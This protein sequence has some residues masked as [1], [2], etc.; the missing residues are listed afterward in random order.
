[1]PDISLCVN[2]DCPLKD[3]CYRR[4]AEPSQLQSYSDFKYD[5]NL[6]TC[7]NYISMKDKTKQL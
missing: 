6:K 5:C 4:Q 7:W 3:T 1:M 2:D